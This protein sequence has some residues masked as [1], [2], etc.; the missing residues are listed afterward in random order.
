MNIKISNVD[1]T[2]SKTPILKNVNMTMNGGNIYGITG[3]NGSGKSVLL[4]AICGFIEPK[5]GTIIVNDVD[6][7]KT[8][9]FP[10]DTRALL[11]KSEYLND[12]S[13]VENLRDLASIQHKIDDHIIYATINDVN[14]ITE[15][16]KKFKKC[17]LGTKQKVGIAQ[18]LMENPG[19]MI[20]DEPFNGIDNESINKIREII[21]Q[22]KAE[23]HLII[24]ATHIKEDI[25]QLCDSTYKV[26]DNTVT[27]LETNNN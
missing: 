27:K 13:C 8:K 10:S 12:L 11:D 21:K 18:V 19:I 17:S 3:R 20:F 4:K 7:Y 22:K 2:I 15:C 14:L 25:D 9:T 6:I 23:G 16:E 1:I 26:E 5:A 24:I